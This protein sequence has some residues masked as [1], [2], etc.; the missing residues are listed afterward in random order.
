VTFHNGERKEQRQDTYNSASFVNA[1]V[2][3]LR[4]ACKNGHIWR[5]EQQSGH[6][7]CA[8][9]NTCDDPDCGSTERTPT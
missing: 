8:W 6:K 2:T 3:M 4:N 9:C 7:V 1:A 5:T